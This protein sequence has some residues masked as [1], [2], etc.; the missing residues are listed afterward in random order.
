[1]NGFNSSK[2]ISSS[3]SSWNRRNKSQNKKQQ[4]WMIT[5][6]SIPIRMRLLYLSIF[7]SFF[8]C[9]NCS[10]IS[11]FESSKLSCEG[12]SNCFYCYS[13]QALL[14][15]SVHFSSCSVITVL[16]NN[17]SSAFMVS[18]LMNYS[19]GTSLNPLTL[20]V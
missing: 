17:L 16:M 15:S 18:C 1:M 12:F 2:K 5:Q 13:I 14:I 19:S 9:S 4:S 8:C 6:N 10:R 11:T 3:Y 7:V 20:P